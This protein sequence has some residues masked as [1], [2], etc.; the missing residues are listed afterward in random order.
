MRDVNVGAG[1]SRGETVILAAG[2]VGLAVL[3]GL[4]GL[5]ADTRLRALAALFVF[6][7]PLGELARRAMVPALPLDAIRKML[8]AL[9]LGQAMLAI[10]V[11]V[12]WAAE[13][14]LTLALVLTLTALSVCAV[15]AFMRR[16][17]SRSVVAT[18]RD[19]LILVLL[20]VPLLPL[21]QYSDSLTAISDSLDHVGSVRKRVESNH[22]F[23]PSAFYAESRENGPDARKGLLHGELALVASATRTSPLVL[24][25]TLPVFFGYWALLG[26]FATGRA[27]FGDDTR[28][29]VAAFLFLFTFE[30]GLDGAWLTRLGHP[31]RAIHGAY[32]TLWALLIDRSARPP[33]L[34]LALLGFGLA[35]MHAFGPIQLGAAAVFLGL[36]A[37]LIGTPDLRASVRPVLRGLAWTIVGAV[38]YLAYRLVVSTPALDSIHTEP[39]GLFLLGER[40]YTINP[41]WLVRSWGYTG[42]ISIP[43][44]LLA[45]GRARRDPAWAFMAGGMIGSL[46]IVANPVAT[47]VLYGVV[48]YL[49]LRLTWFTPHIFLLSDALV[50]AWR[51]LR[52]R[53]TPGPAIP[54]ALSVTVL[55]LTGGYIAASAQSCVARGSFGPFAGGG[56]RAQIEDF[57]SI[58][59]AIGERSVVLS[60]PA[61]G[62]AV[63]ALTRHFTVSASA[64][65]TPPNDPDARIRLRDTRRM[66]SPYVN[67]TET[68]TLLRDYG[69]EWI[70]LNRSPE[71][72]KLLYLYFAGLE[73]CAASEEKFD[74]RPDLYEPILEEGRLRLYRLTDQARRGPLPESASAARAWPEPDEQ[75]DPVRTEEDGFEFRGG[76][77]THGGDPSRSTLRV[78]SAWRR[79][80]DVA[81]ENRYLMVWLDRSADERLITEQ[82]FG[83]VARVVRDALRGERTRARIGFA[84]GDGFLSPNDWPRG[85]SVEDTSE[86]RV[87]PSLA[88]GVYDVRIELVR[89]PFFPNARPSDFLSGPAAGRGHPIGR[90][91]IAAEENHETSS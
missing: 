12:A 70:L 78:T 52:G 85:R 51:T 69:V 23:P 29:M 64:Q 88:P 61:T 62:Y 9:S 81:E 90:I 45:L 14:T 18:R 44:A 43:L 34:F 21:L 4:P 77:V 89:V 7:Y 87:P 63:P 5:F 75:G 24:W 33:A 30:G 39:Q 15:G 32:W 80:D 26:I 20:L 72:T 10:V 41:L 66:L 67:D 58:D 76:R 25:D 16:D 71:P 50:G 38:P 73:T 47:P 79:T 54:F 42:L 74:A 36:T 46:C 19:R 1:S 8:V 82:R 28:A 57:R 53:L 27:L 31:G 35:A 22:V 65:H 55:L 60:D 3:V 11:A 68:V 49:V 13:N 86:L 91:T 6:V 56:F 48:G 83:R 2:L 17:R 59:T 40:L 37:L 84:P